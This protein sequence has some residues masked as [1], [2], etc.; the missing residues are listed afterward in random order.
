MSKQTSKTLLIIK[1][2]STFPEIESKFGD[3]DRWFISFFQKDGV[4]IWTVQVHDGDPLPA[5][6]SVDAVLITGSPAMVSDRE[7]WSENTA[8]WLRHY[9]TG[10]GLTLGVCYGHQLL[11][12]ALGGQ[13]ENHPQGREIGTLPVSLADAAKDDPLLYGLPA[14]FSAHLTHQ[15]SVIRLPQKAVL[16]ASSAHEPHQAF[17]YGERC[18]GV[19]FHPEFTG[20]IMAAYLD[21]HASNLRAQKVDVEALYQLANLG[22]PVASQVLDQFARIIADGTGPR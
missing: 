20:P 1:T 7:P 6:G 13:V 9:V 18:W 15:Q 19:Q 16:L 4:D 2:G 12:H 17:R 10:G 21:R 8:E 11:A 14:T 22:A 3:F 5:H